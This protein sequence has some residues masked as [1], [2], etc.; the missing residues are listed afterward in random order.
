MSESERLMDEDHFELLARRLTDEVR[1]SAEAELKRRYSWMGVIA[2]ILTSGMLA[3]LVRQQTFD[4][5]VTVEAAAE[6]IR[7]AAEAAETVT[8]S[9]EGVRESLEEIRQQTEN[10]NTRLVGGTKGQFATTEELRSQL[11]ALAAIVD[12]LVQD[13]IGGNEAPTNLASRVERI[14]TS[15]SES[16]SA[17]EVRQRSA[18][19]IE[20]VGF[21]AT[22]LSDTIVEEL[23][24]QGYLPS[25]SSA[26]RS[27]AA[28]DYTGIS[29]ADGLPQDVGTDIVEAVARAAPFINFVCSGGV[30]RTIVGVNRRL[31]T[32]GGSISGRTCQPLSDF[33]DVR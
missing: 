25:L 15:I 28:E 20:V 24:R 3:L 18:Y 10:I 22:G 32:S 16:E 4:T 21:S 12:D 31:I 30:S 7:H 5:Q 29:L 14:Q 1:A 33:L 6:R 23:R 8:L 26:R 13:R 27:V 2:L 11:N 19:P 9:V 17:M